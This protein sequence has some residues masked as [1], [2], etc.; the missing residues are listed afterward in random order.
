[1][2]YL[3]P[4]LN[5]PPTPQIIQQIENTITK[6][7]YHCFSRIDK[8]RLRNFEAKVESLYKKAMDKYSAV[9][10]DFNFELEEI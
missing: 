6:T 3:R 4:K 8:K 2:K 10:A 1:V 9:V 5:T 7:E